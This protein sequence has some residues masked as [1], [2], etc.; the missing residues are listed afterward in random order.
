MVAR[1]LKVHPNEAGLWVYAASWEFETNGNAA[2]ARS[3][4]QQG[5][6]CCR[7][8]PQLWVEYF[9]MVRGAGE[10]HRSAPV[11]GK[12]CRGGYYEDWGSL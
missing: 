2:A 9:N 5:L 10:A 7:D 3:L 4:M 6:R 8:S 11:R 1:A 12:S